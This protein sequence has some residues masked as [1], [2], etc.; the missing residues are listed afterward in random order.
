MNSAGVAAPFA[1]YAGTTTLRASTDLEADGA[2]L[3]RDGYILVGTSVYE[4]REPITPTQI[5]TQGEKVRADLVLYQRGRGISRAA[6]AIADRPEPDPGPPPS[7]APD[8]GTSGPGAA[9]VTTTHPRDAV[10]NRPG[11]FA[12]SMVPTARLPV[13]SATFWR[14]RMTPSLP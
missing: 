11:T 9:T 1:P 2:N 5:I 12:T 10:P 7:G 13:H 3:I 8:A 4:G 14:K 6:V